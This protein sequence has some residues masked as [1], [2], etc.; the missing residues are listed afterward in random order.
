MRISQLLS[1]VDA[2]K[3]LAGGFLVRV[4]VVHSRCVPTT[5]SG[6]QD[7]DMKLDFGVSVFGQVRDLK[8]SHARAVLRRA[9]LR[10]TKQ[11]IIKLQDAAGGTGTAV[12]IADQRA[13]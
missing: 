1:A 4:D 9:V 2:G 3:P 5:A 10:E 11:S 13:L 7:L 8:P 6:F 12:V